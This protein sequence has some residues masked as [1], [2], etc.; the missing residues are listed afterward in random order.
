MKH[1]TNLVMAGTIAQAPEREKK[2]KGKK[3][4]EQK[5]HETA[6]E[7]RAFPLGLFPASF[8]GRQTDPAAFPCR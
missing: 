7:R 5:K 4:R 3:N 6:F 8:K 2:T 1:N